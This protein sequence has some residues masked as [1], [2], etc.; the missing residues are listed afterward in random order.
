MITFLIVFMVFL[1]ARGAFGVE[2]EK[3]ARYFLLG[4]ILLFLLSIG[5]T[6]GLAIW[7]S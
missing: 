6:V 1:A 5:L 4:G 2:W 3:P 7:L